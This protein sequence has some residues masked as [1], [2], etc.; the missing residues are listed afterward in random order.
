MLG[1]KFTALANS[2]FTQSDDASLQLKELLGTAYEGLKLKL[3]KLKDK[4]HV[5]RLP[6]YFYNH[7]DY[8]Y[9][10]MTHFGIS[11]CGFIT[12]GGSLQIYQEQPTV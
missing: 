11:H 10:R 2:V 1:V 8:L 9:P 5:I 3:P 12:K 4:V 6:S 7:Y